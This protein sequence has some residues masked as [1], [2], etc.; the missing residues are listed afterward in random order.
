MSHGAGGD[1]PRN[2]DYSVAVRPDVM[3]E[4]RDGTK[5]AT[6]I[7]LPADQTTKA[8]DENEFPVLLQRT[9]YDKSDPNRIE[10]YGKWFAKRGYVVGIQDCR[11]RY[12]SEGDFY[13]LRD[14]APDGYDTVEWFANQPYCDG[15]VGTFGT[16]YMAWVQSALATLDPPHLEAMFVNQGA[17]NAWEA[18]LRHNGAFELRWLCWALTFG[19]GLSKRAKKNPEIQ[20][21]FADLDVRDL[22][23]SGPARRGQTPLRHL[24]NYQQWAFDLMAS[25]GEDELWGSRGLNF[26]QY[27]EETADVPTVYAGSWYDSYG[28]ATCDN[29][30]ELSEQLE[31][32][33]YLLMGSWIHGGTGSWSKP[34]SGDVA[35]GEEAP[36]EFCE[37]MLDFFDHYLKGLDAW[38][39]V[40]AVQY[41]EMG[42]G[43]GKPDSRGRLHH[44]GTWRTAT[45]W[46]LLDSETERLYIHDSG[47]LRREKPQAEESSTTYQ[48]DP[49]DPVP[50]IGGN[51]SSYTTYEPRDERIE[52]YPLGDR[53]RLSI[54]GQGGHDQR[55]TEETFGATPPYGPLE[56]R[57]DVLVYRTSAL[58]ESITVAGPLRVR[59]FASSDCLGTDFTAKLIDE[60]P[61][62]EAY[63]GGYALNIADSICRAR[64]RGYRST[65]DQIEPG[66]IYEFYMEPYPTA[67][68]FE[69][70]HQIRLDISSSNYPRY[71]VNPN[72]GHSPYANRDAVVATNTVYHEHAHP[73]HIE[74]QTI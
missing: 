63:P 57:D 7:Y 60:Y 72:T 14:E 12:N 36:R 51:C 28:K 49:A 69:K 61:P 40:P 6:D 42:G 22:F 3:I 59:V 46:P 70:G 48:Y 35:F 41:F 16:S 58:K 37:T 71:D 4:M 11:G 9:P 18:T 13:L 29:Y 44:G 19:G 62:S 47:S 21:L 20:Q 39:N 43:T 5:L 25:E 33:Q 54:T 73:T 15:Q 10:Q 45:D 24:P 56:Q 26:E 31:S 74:F 8:I 53:K 50:T 34:Y 68:T 30:I 32:D 17:A 55:T 52:E 66:E 27:Y 23:A 65:P 1:M 38:T 2:P 64:Y 67:N